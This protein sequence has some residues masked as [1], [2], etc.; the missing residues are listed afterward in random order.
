M[1]L[2]DLAGRLD[3]MKED[4][5]F[6]QATRDARVL[7]RN[8]SAKQSVSPLI[9]DMR[10]RKISDFAIEMV[11]AQLAEAITYEFERRVME[12]SNSKHAHAFRICRA[13]A[14]GTTLSWLQRREA[15]KNFNPTHGYA[16]QLA[17]AVR[18]LGGPVNIEEVNTTDDADVDA[19]EGD[20]ITFAHVTR[21]TSGAA[22]AADREEELAND[23]EEEL[24]DEEE[25]EEEEGNEKEYENEHD[26]GLA[27]EYRTWR[28]SATWCECLYPACWGLPCRHMLRLYMQQNL[29]QIPEEAIA[30]LWWNVGDSDA[31]RL[32]VEELPNTQQN[33]RKKRR[34]MR[35]NK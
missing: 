10:K 14:S 17:K 6:Q 35:P 9:T 25:E 7:L 28:C 21:A 13:C 26:Y 8:A 12:K 22:A 2:A 27:A 23:E 20:A 30:G 1:L 4:A 33:T 16:E 18:D 34:S 11:K 19:E 31:V 3:D 24:E 15:A 5:E 29:T 32:R